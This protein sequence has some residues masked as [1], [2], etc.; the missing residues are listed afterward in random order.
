MTR[1]ERGSLKST[2]RF[3]SILDGAKTG[4][5]V[6]RDVEVSDTRKYDYA[7]RPWKVRQTIKKTSPAA[8]AKADNRVPLVRPQRLGP[9]IMDEIFDHSKWEENNL[10]KHL[11]NFCQ[12]NVS[13]SKDPHLA[14]PY[15][16]AEMKLQGPAQAF[17]T[18][19]LNKIKDHVVRMYHEHKKQLGQSHGPPTNT[20]SG[21]DFSSRNITTRQDVIRKLSRQFARFPDPSTMYMTSD[22]VAKVKASYAYIYDWEQ[23]RSVE[24]KSDKKT[25]R[26]PWNVAFRE[27]CELKAKAVSGGL[28]KTVSGDFYQYS[29]LKLPRA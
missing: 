11:E 8:S 9:F 1:I 29:S 17:Y 3:C 13:H 27:L 18:A 5:K 4:L 22:T 15:E 28:A 16:E 24:K 26:F 10:K 25:S 2:F 23:N 14:A 12:E 21:A 20:Q 6:K 19:D 7:P